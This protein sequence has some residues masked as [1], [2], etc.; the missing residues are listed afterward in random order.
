MYG[1]HITSHFTRRERIQLTSK[2]LENKN[3]VFQ[4]KCFNQREMNLHGNVIAFI[5]WQH[6][7]YYRLR[8]PAKQNTPS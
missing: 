8:V 4:T 3:V 6:T 1:E 5:V 7:Q 2:Y